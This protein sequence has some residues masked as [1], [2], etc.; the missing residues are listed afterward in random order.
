MVTSTLAIILVVLITIAVLA[1]ILPSRR[2]LLA[3]EEYDH[4]GLARYRAISAAWR[5]LGACAGV[6]VGGLLIITQ[7]AWYGRGL[8]AL[9]AP[10]V[11][12][13][14]LL[15]AIVVGEFFARGGLRAHDAKDPEA[16]SAPKP[17]FGDILPARLLAAVA[18]VTVLLF[19]LLA[20][21]WMTGSPDGRGR[22]GRSLHVPSPDGFGGATSGPW[23]GQFYG[24]W[25][26]P[27]ALVLI[28][29]LVLALLVV[30][31]HRRVAGDPDLAG[32]DAAARRSQAEAL[33]GAAGL[34]LSLLSLGVA[35]TMAFALFDVTQPSS[36]GHTPGIGYNL[37]AWA[38]VLAAVASAAVTV[39]S[40]AALILP[41]SGATRRYRAVSR[42]TD[43]RVVEP[44]G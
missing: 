5:A 21:A 35:M 41:G 26:Y 28:A 23:P 19:A 40:L 33:V 20:A 22:L 14:A 10:I 30:R 7:S 4:P 11:L 3:T 37:A 25:A 39:M 42:E 17:G 6:V 16:A 8:G 34:A 2:R 1:V 27:L 36:L 24:V 12:G 43:T 13:L 44:V 18:G 15:V 31:L 29:G 32:A 38:C 9:F